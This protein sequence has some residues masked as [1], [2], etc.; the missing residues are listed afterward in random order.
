MRKDHPKIKT[1]IKAI[2]KAAKEL[3][4]LPEDVVRVVKSWLDAPGAPDLNP[5][6]DVRNKMGKS[7]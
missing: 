6:T 7:W 3:G 5:D 1:V 2:K 4:C